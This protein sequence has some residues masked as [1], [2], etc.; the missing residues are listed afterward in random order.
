MDDSENEN[1]PKN[2]SKK[3]IIIV[4][5]VFVLIIFIGLGF[6]LYFLFRNNNKNNT[7]N[8]N[9]NSNNNNITNYSP[10]FFIKNN[11]NC[12]YMQNDN[13]GITNCTN[14]VIITDQPAYE[15]TMGNIWILNNGNFINIA[16]GGI[17]TSDGNNL[18]GSNNSSNSQWTYSKDNKTISNSN[19]Q[20]WINNSVSI[21][22]TECVSN[23]TSSMQWTI[24]PINF[25]LP[26]TSFNIK[27]I[28]TGQCLIPTNTPITGQ[29]NP[30]VIF[31]SCPSQSVWTSDNGS[32]K[33]IQYGTLMNAS[34]G[35]VSL[36]SPSSSQ[37]INSLWMY[38]P[39]SQT[40]ESFG[41][42]SCLYEAPTQ[43]DGNILPFVG[44]CGETTYNTNP[45]T[46]EPIN[47]PIKIN[48]AQLSFV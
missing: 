22:L 42:N 5:I 44:Y 48:P 15:F 3:V 24:S 21:E 23:P 2:N 35:Y 9:N 17:I 16:N 27:D 37:P 25:N 47:P 32:I 29:S 43:Y 20:C 40:L 8:N 36:L 26:T 1:E 41:Y 30:A 19:N 18:V 38:N 28:T 13:I 46:N 7:N 12:V 14:T 4:I 45:I 6:L 31:S 33:S 39:S 11:D 10:Y 34:S